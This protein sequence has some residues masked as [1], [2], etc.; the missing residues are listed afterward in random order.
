M[1]AYKLSRG[2]TT[3]IRTADNAHIPFAE[4]NSDY[5][6]FKAWVQEGNQPDE[7]DSVKVPIPPTVTQTPA[8]LAPQ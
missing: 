7:A 3:V 6:E 8:E 4:G 5:E 2:G 1:K